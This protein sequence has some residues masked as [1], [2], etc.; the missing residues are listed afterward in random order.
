MKAY[1][2]RQVR[3]TPT[4]IA[5]VRRPHPYVMIADSQQIVSIFEPVKV[6]IHRIQ[7]LRHGSKRGAVMISTSMP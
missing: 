2:N 7:H 4:Q 1:F 5:T 6:R 3:K